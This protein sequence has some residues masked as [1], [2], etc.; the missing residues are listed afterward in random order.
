MS[1][2]SDFDSCWFAV[3]LDS[4]ALYSSSVAY[5]ATYRG[6]G[7]MSQVLVKGFSY[8]PSNPGLLSIAFA[9]TNSV[10]WALDLDLINFTRTA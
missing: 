9:C 6:N 8:T 2:G 10:K 3:K 7:T 5:D 4:L 1:D